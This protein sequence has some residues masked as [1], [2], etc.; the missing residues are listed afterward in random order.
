MADWVAIKN[1]Y[2]TTTISQRALAEKYGVSQ[3]AIAD[4]SKKENWTQERRNN[5]IKTSSKLHRKTIEKI[6]EKE[7]QQIVDGMDLMTDMLKDMADF[8][9]KIVAAMSEIEI[10]APERTATKKEDDQI[11]TE[12]DKSGIE[13]V[14]KLTSAYAKILK[15]ISD[16]VDTQ[17]RYL[18]ENDECEDDGLLEAL[19]NAASGFDSDDSDLLPLE[20][21]DG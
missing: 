16:I 1:E 2:I 10:G 6:A 7:S 20:K 3:R 12:K 5:F 17:N 14:D 18:E 4:K 13:K 9:Q 19:K 8:R 11:I 15:G 21:T